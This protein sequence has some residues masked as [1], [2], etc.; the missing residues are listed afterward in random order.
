MSIMRVADDAPRRPAGRYHGSK[1]TQGPDIIGRLPADHDTYDEAFCGMLSV[2]LRKERSLIEV[3]ND[4]SGDV[5]NFFR[6]LRERPDELIRLIDLT[7][8]AWEEW[9]LSYKPADDPVE[10][11]RRFYARAYMSIAGPTS[12]MTNPGFRRQKMFSRGSDGRKMMT[13]AAKTFANVDHLWTVARRL[14]GVTIENEDALVHIR[15]YDHPRTLFYVDPPYMPE[16]R[17]RGADSAYEHEMTE[18]DHA[19]LLATLNGLKG[20]VALSGYRCPMYDDSLTGWTRH[21]K[22]MRV[23]GRGS[24]V[25]SLWL[26]PAAVE[27]VARGEEA[28]R[29]AA[30]RAAAEEAERRRNHRDLP[31]FANQAEAY[32]RE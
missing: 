31:L 23:N 4:R 7:P 29:R 18:D 21:D 26:N 5:V 32:H 30:E 6:V 17:V 8:F 19:A 22:L 2:L 16:T 15:R 3:V 12:T 28:A 25:E 1:H 20:M 14:K 24:K 13:P 9:K 27:A 11:A 10:R